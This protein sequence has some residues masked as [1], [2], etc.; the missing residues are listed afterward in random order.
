M[1]LFTCGSSHDLK[2]SRLSLRMRLAL[3]QGPLC[4]R[5]VSCGRAHVLALDSKNISHTGS[6]VHKG[7]HAGL[8]SCLS[9]TSNVKSFSEP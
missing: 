4:K 7:A 8:S 3:G 1:D 9:K 6:S 2:S 5:V